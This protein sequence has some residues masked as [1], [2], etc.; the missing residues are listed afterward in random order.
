MATSA[1]VLF[2]GLMLFIFTVISGIFTFVTIDFSTM[3]SPEQVISQLFEQAAVGMLGIFGIL[4]I[5]LALIGL[6]WLAWAFQNAALYVAVDGVIKTNQVSI[7][8]YFI[9]GFKN[10]FRM[11]LLMVTSALLYLPFFL[12]QAIAIYFMILNPDPIQIVISIGIVII[13][14]ILMLLLALALLHAP[15]ILISENTG[16]IRSI[17]L[18]FQLF[19]RSFGQVF[20]TC[21][22]T[23]AV[24][25]SYIMIGMMIH[26]P[27]L[28]GLLD[29]TGVL[30][31]VLSIFMQIIQAIYGFAGSSL[32]ITI[33]GL[34]LAY[35]YHK[36]LRANILPGGGDEDHHEPI[37]TFK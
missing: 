35:R 26:L 21:L 36:Y 22:L 6:S 17:R 24:T 32:L 2:F 4:L 16:V 31:T 29:P 7:G 9:K 10:M 28:F 12:I 3:E 13:L 5:L 1:V 19:R 15:Y 8:N 33:N 18:S 30:V 11:F 27:S 37:F 25:I 20:L 34:I 14:L 23:I